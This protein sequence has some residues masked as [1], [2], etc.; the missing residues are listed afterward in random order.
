MRTSKAQQAETRQR[1]LRAAVTLMSA[2]GFEAT[3]LKQI[4]AEAGVGDVTVYKYFASKERL[5]L[6]YFEA[7]VAQALA[8]WE[9]TPGQLEFGLQE[10]LQL[11]LDALL[12]QLAPDRSFV[13]LA[14]R[15]LHS[16]PLLMADVGLPGKPGL[17]NAV[18][19]ML[20]RAE[21]VGEIAPCG[22]KGALGALMADYAYGVIAFWLND[23][24]EHQG[25]TTQ[26]L[27]HS[28]EILV[29]VLR[30]GLVNKLLGLGGFLLRSQMG[31]W[32]DRGPAL[33]QALALVKQG[34]KP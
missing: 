9:A 25:D 31:R 17:Q 21:D 7:A 6:G 3:T 29:L 20:A 2:Q 33:V 19:Q 14:R 18:E 30:S 13:A 12:E 32:L 4:A 22:F 16:Q 24:S 11:L 1:I 10:R 23:E 27:D 28:L 26:L 5:L 34:L 15:V 8:Q